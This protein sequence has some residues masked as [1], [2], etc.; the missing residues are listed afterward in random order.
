MVRKP[1]SGGDQVCSD[2]NKYL[3]NRDSTRNEADMHS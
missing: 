1:C 3:Y 2:F